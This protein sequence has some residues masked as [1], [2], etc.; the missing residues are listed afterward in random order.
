MESGQRVAVDLDFQ[1][2]MVHSEIRSLCQQLSY[3]YSANTKAPRP[4]C[5]H[6]TSLN[7]SLTPHGRLAA[8]WKALGAERALK[9][10]S[11]STRGRAGETQGNSP[12]SS[13]RAR[14]LDHQGVARTDD[15]GFQ[16]SLS[17]ARCPKGG[18]CP[19]PRPSRLCLAAPGIAWAT[20]CI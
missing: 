14:E 12:A 15:R 13:I 2:K 9:G 10:S 3:C 7:V 1:D 17:R 16:V 11:A 5:L 8:P 18:T 4:F 19:A 6:F 20:W